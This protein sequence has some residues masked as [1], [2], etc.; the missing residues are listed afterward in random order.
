ME[1]AAFSVHITFSGQ[2]SKSALTH[3]ACSGKEE[4]YVWCVYYQR[5]GKKKQLCVRCHVQLM[6]WKT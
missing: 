2:R 6:T 4:E 3:K 1:Q 5:N